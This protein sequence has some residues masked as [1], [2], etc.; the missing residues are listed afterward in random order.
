MAGDEPPPD[1]WENH[2]SRS[3]EESAAERDLDLDISETILEL[4]PVFEA[5]AHPRRRYLVYTLAEETKW[6]LDDLAIKLAAWETDT[7]EANIA[8]LTR[9]E[10]YTS[11]YHAHVPKLVDLDV[12][13]FDDDTE[14]IT[15]GS[16]AV[17]VLTVL[18]GAGGS[19][20][21]RQETHARSQFDRE[22]TR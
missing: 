21:T 3:A 13:E 2:S 6:S 5:I 17:Q 12:I 16:H 8:T 1:E 14:T 22:D 9:Q 10:M 11:L 7:E 20:D 15:P 4:Q 18:E 19:L